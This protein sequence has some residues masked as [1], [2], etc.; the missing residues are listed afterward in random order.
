ML[1]DQTDE[2]FD[3]ISGCGFYPEVAEAELRR[4][5][6]RQPVRTHLV[7]TDVTLDADGVNMQAEILALTDN[8]IV[9]WAA[10][11]DAD[12]STEE[13]DDAD[14]T[15]GTREPQ[16]TTRLYS[17]SRVIPLR[18]ISDLRVLSTFADPADA[19]FGDLPDTVRLVFVTDTMDH[20]AIDPVRCDDDECGGGHGFYG[21]A[22]NSA[23]MFADS[24]EVGGAE[25]VKDLLKVARVAGELIAG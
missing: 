16:P 8:R 11:E 2:L 13:S 7:V 12:H 22:V 9:Y 5:L 6:N 20:L 14:G 17:H 1:P 21:D 23:I 25:K 3:A 18:R 15:D 10:Y 19:R 4:L 24:K